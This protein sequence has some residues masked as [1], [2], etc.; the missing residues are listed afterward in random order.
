MNKYLVNKASL[1]EAG[2]K[3]EVLGLV[4]APGSNVWM[5]LKSRAIAENADL[6][7][8]AF[9][10]SILATHVN[11][12]GSYPPSIGVSYAC[13]ISPRVVRRREVQ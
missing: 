9:F 7:R 1:I 10:G 13:S 6:L 8:S 12:S 3:P 2:E 5:L 11:K 4:D